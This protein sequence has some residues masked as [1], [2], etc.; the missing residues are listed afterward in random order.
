MLSRPKKIRACFV[1][2]NA[3]PA[4]DPHVA[5]SFGGIETR[6][7]L[8]ARALAQHPDF[9]VSFL[10][11]H[12]KPPRCRMYS[13][14][15]LH[16]LIDRFY[17]IR[18]SLH[19]RLRFMSHFPW[20]QLH[21]PQYSDLVYLPL[22]TCL[23]IMKPK[24]APTDPL[25]LVSNL[26][27]D[28]FLT[29]GV[30][31]FSARVIASGHAQQHPVLLFLGSDGDLDENYLSEKEFANTYGDSSKVC[32]WTIQ[33]ADHILCQTSAQQEKLKRIFDR[34]AELIPNPI[35][36]E[37]WDHLQ[38]QPIDSR[39]HAGLSR[40][41]LWVGR[42]DAVHK[43][44][45]GL[46]DVAQR[47]PDV[48]FL[49][50]LNPRDDLVEAEIKRHAPSNVKIVEHVPFSMIPA[51]FAKATVLINTSSLEGFPNTFLQAAISSVPI[52]SLNVEPE[53]LKLSDA[54]MCAMGR[55]EELA[56]YVQQV[57][58]SSARNTSAREYAAKHHSLQAQTERL[59][60]ALRDALSST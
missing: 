48:Q 41:A 28:L 47:C 21:R 34:D 26:D 45:Q 16:A 11:R 46:L 54:G 7:W 58:D 14:V 6:S 23:K 30:Q 32:L 39:Y 56:N 19:S 22:L 10:V 60:E 51:L 17:P 13:G 37:Q 57:W 59:A 55:T 25:E 24:Q 44:P 52:A 12:S 5:G 9:E 4:I 3:Y 49:M 2:L 15:V 38:Q 27:A 42:A 40:Y 36:I 20:V 1:A 33:Q 8:F 18:D 29:F 31:S 53:F 35:D 50:I 43:C